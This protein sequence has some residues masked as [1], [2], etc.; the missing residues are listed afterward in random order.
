MKKII[1]YI[2]SAALVLT[3]LIAL[4][5]QMRRTAAAELALTENT[6]AAVSEV[7]AGLETL[8][9]SLDKLLLTSSVRQTAELLSQT[10]LSANQVQLGLSGLPDTQGQRTETQAYLSRLS[11]LSQSCLASLA[12]DGSLSASARIEL[13]DMLTGL[14]LLQSEIT[15]A[16]QAM[17]T[18]EDL[19][20]ALPESELTAPPSAR[21]LTAYKALPSGEVSMG[22][23][24]QIAKE[25]VGVER[26]TSVAHAP[27]TSGA[28]PAYG[29]TVQTA[30]VQLNLEVTRRGGK[31]LL[32]VPETA[33]FPMRKT[34]QECSAAALTFLKARGFASMECLYY[35]VYDGLCV[36]TCAYV[37]NG[38][39]I[40]PDRVLVQVR[41]D[42]AEIVGIE[43]R[44]YWK[45]H[46]PRKLQ[47]PLLTEQEARAALSEDANVT[48]VRQCLLPV[49]EQERLCWQFSMTVEDGEYIAYIDAMTGEELRLEK[50]MQLESGSIPA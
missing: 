15:L 9:L 29:V 10:T 38:V 13:R 3:L 47:T 22:E 26:V 2:L 23:A 45:N 20:A 7:A 43:A 14:R 49:K 44:N 33:S 18:G 17:L 28:L 46:I 50:V 11:D 41:M 19:A 40:W 31:V 37:Q 25:F 24:L 8:T 4:N 12:V 36:L 5:T 27:D 34:V 6:R 32:M 1:L 48:A 21:E 35:Q 30:D 16:Q 39:L 42:T